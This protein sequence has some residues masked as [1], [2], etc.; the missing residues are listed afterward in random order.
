VIHCEKL[1]DCLTDQLG[2]AAS[3][4]ERDAVEQ[5]ILVFI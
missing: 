3:L 1:I 2:A 4:G 5:P